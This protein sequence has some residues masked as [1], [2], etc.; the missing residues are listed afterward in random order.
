MGGGRAFFLPEGV[1]DP[2]PDPSY[3]MNKASRT[4]GLNL[5]EVSLA[6]FYDKDT[7]KVKL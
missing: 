3:D 2:D 7:S 4:D 1:A 5:V 6:G